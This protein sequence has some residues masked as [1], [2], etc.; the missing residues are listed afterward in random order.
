MLALQLACLKSYELTDEVW[1]AHSQSGCSTERVILEYLDKV[2]D[3]VKGPCCLIMDTC[4]AHRMESVKE[5]ARALDIELVFVPPSC[6]DLVQPLDI[7]VFG[8]LKS[9]AIMLIHIT[10]IISSILSLRV[11]ECHDLLL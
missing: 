2:A 10:L 5:K 3:K 1:C 4:A 6:T 7:K 9:Y 8:A 11:Q